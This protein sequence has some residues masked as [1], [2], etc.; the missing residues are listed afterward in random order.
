MRDGVP[1]REKN[2]DNDGAI[3]VGET[4]GEGED[5]RENPPGDMVPKNR[6]EGVYIEERV[7]EA[8]W[9][10]KAKAVNEAPIERLNAEEME[11]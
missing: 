8:G 11:G 5:D 3:I 2:V 10:D 1:I 4:N 7:R 6:R 9:D